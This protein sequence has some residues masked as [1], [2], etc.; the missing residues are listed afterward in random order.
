MIIVTGGAG[1]IGSN[2]I[3]GLNDLGIDD[4]LVAD[5]LENSAKHLNL[6]R[7]KFDDYM[8]KRDFLP[9]L[10]SGSFEVEAIFH[11]G[12]C[13]DT[14]ETDGRYMMKNNFEYSK[15]VLHYCLEHGVRFLYASSA[16][17]Y[18][19]GDS[20]FAESPENEYPLNVYAYSK[21]AFD[22]YVRRIEEPGI[23]LAGLRYFNVYGPQENHKG[24]MASVAYHF[25][26][27]YKDGGVIKPFEG[28]ENFL[29]DFIYVKDVV[30]VNMFLYEN[31]EVSG[32]FNCGT[33]EARSFAAIADVFKNKFS[34]VEVNPVPFPEQLKGKY[35][36]YTQAD[37]TKLREAGYDKP[38][39]SLEDGVADYLSVLEADGGYLK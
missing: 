2:I 25:F 26:N 37:M 10:E 39:T 18:G 1:F 38:F 24:R 14:M 22:N 11:Q 7:L 29:R 21:F 13:S 27:Q 4:I 16:S 31:P 23:Q 3:R 32:I 17:V 35:Q 5:N 8:D 9:M 36:K 30:N 6:N 12:A 19:N 28:S 15:S 33:G 34:G 20:G